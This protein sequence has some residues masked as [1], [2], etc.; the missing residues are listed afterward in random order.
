MEIIIATIDH[1][2]HE[3]AV[4][5]LVKLR[6]NVNYLFARQFFIVIFFSQTVLGGKRLATSKWMSSVSTGVVKGCD[7]SVCKTSPTAEL[8]QEHT[9]IYTFI[10]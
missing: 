6:I 7:G 10:P 4:C 9:L 8:T 2:D 1:T 3:N 5:N